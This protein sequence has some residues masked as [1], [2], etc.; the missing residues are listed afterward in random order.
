MT[1]RNKFGRVNLNKILH[2][3]IEINN[4]VEVTVKVGKKIITLSGK[5]TEFI[6]Q[7]TVTPNFRSPKKK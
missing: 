4:L 1:K 3:E 5:S 2:E 6:L 7:Q